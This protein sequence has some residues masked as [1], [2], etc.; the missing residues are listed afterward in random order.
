[1]FEDRTFDDPTN[2]EISS[3][4]NPQI[5]HLFKKVYFFFTH[6]LTFSV[7]RHFCGNKNSTKSGF[8]WAWFWAR[9]FDGKKLLDKNGPNNTLCGVK[10]NLKAF[11]WL[12]DHMESAPIFRPHIS[13]CIYQGQSVNFVSKYW[14]SGTDLGNRDDPRPAP[15]MCPKSFPSFVL[16]SSKPLSPLSSKLLFQE[17]L[18]LHRNFWG[19]IPKTINTRLYLTL[20]CDNLK[21]RMFLQNLFSWHYFLSYPHHST[22]IQPNNFEPT[23][24]CNVESTRSLDHGS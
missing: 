13:M 3:P 9:S 6:F 20:L 11:A 15:G 17:S 12:T 23:A 24:I 5:I 16:R 22:I 4:T 14:P 10:V 2:S 7:Q 18:R 8:S 19:Q 1:M 21:R